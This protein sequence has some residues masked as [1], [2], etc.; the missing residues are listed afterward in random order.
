M[1]DPLYAKDLLRL[2]A[3]STGAGVLNPCDISGVASNPICGDRVRV[4]INIDHGRIVRLAHE[5]QA[6]VL[7]QASASILGASLDNADVKTI[8][9]LHESVSAMLRGDGVPEPPFDDYRT[10]L[11]AAAHR[12]R[13]KC[14]LLPIE[15]VL[16]AFATSPTP[17]GRG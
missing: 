1:D 15:A 10:L 16:N 13:H 9:N 2:A 17:K 5:T 8:E 14:V 6:C 7:A 4:T 12:N 3:R 11:G